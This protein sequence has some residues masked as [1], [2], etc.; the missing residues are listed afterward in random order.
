[1]KRHSEKRNRGR[2]R[3]RSINA[4]LSASFSLL[5]AAVISIQILAVSVLFSSSFIRQKNAQ[6][7]S[8]LETI[9]GSIESRM[10]NV[11]KLTQVL[12]NESSVQASFEE[13]A[14]TP[15][16][17]ELLHSLYIYGLQSISLIDKD[18]FILASGASAQEQPG[19]HEFQVK[20]REESF[21]APHA[22]PYQNPKNDPLYNTR[23][24]YYF[25]LR[26]QPEYSSYGY[27]QINITRD[28]LF[29]ERS[30]FIT[31]QF[32][33]FYVI[34][35]QGNLVYSTDSYEYSELLRE[36]VNFSQN[37][38]APADE[39]K[40]DFYYF[41]YSLPS[42]PDWH[43][44]GVVSNTAMMRS[45]RTM[46]TMVVA[47]GL[48]GILFAFGLSF[49][50]S[51]RITRPIKQIGNSM[52]LFE[53]GQTPEKLNVSA[54]SEIEELAHGFNTMLDAIQA[55]IATIYREQ[56]E[57]KLAEVTA[58]QFQLQSL[59]HQINPHFLYNT[60]N[61]VNYLAMDEQYEEIR[62]FI[63][64]LNQLLR[65]TLS[66]THENVELEEE[67]GLLRAYAHIMEYRYPGMFELHL[68]VPLDTLDCIVPKLILQPLVEN[69]LLHGI[70]PTGDVGNVWIH[71]KKSSRFVTL[72]V[73]DDG[74]GMDKE[75]LESLLSAASGFNSVGLKNVND[76]LVL[77]YGKDSALQITS[78]PGAGT[79]ICFCIP[80]HQEENQA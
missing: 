60:L 28:S 16:A 33:Y 59:Q 21:T 23:L 55:N 9:S 4:Q 61:I 3:F 74:V 53:S 13:K 29:D 71:A 45:I 50:V 80:I 26:E 39:Q 44:V 20:N 30:S 25:R 77:C 64:S 48:V 63:Q 69:A 56:E 49:F 31:S 32:E 24:S 43:L 62:A 73:Q 57:K 65:A 10:N 51:Q 67:L 46:V 35:G 47:I 36:A 76:R 34:D 18:G 79:T 27:A 22:Y 15:R 11:R 17:E 52:R 75:R 12:R 41:H 6:M 78:H 54:S 7:N 5:I 68:D 8:S 58:L 19:F 40:G 37:R 70:F 1:L 72:S 2:L 14:L 66:N 38:Y 42:Y